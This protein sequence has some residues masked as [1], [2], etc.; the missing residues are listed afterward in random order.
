MPLGLMLLLGSGCLVHEYC[1]QHTVLFNNERLAPM[2]YRKLFAASC[3]M[4]F[5]EPCA[6]VRARR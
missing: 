1:K 3:L 5:D 4:Q 2:V 6:R